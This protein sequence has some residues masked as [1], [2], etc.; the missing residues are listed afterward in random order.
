MFFLLAASFSLDAQIPAESLS[1]FY[2]FSGSTDDV[3]F[4]NGA[5]LIGD[6]NLTA[7]R[8]GF[9]NCA[10]SFGGHDT[11]LMLIQGCCGFQV[12]QDSSFTISLWY[13]HG[14]AD[15]G[16]FE[17]LFYKGW[18]PND[19][20][21]FGIS[22]YD[23]NTPLMYSIEE[24]LWCDQSLITFPDDSLWH[25]LAIVYEPDHWAMY[26]DNQLG[27]EL[28]GSQANIHFMAADVHLGTNFE[29]HLDDIAFYNKA[30]NQNEILQLYNAPS[31][32]T[33]GLG[34]LNYEIDVDI[35]PQPATEVLSIRLKEI[36]AKTFEILTVEGKLAHSENI[37][38]QNFQIQ[39]DH[40]SKGLY[41]IR[42]L[43]D[44]QVLG[45]KSFIVN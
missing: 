22:L 38:T 28:N 18:H 30:L 7:D 41:T 29:G 12:S 2:P 3:I 14:S 42:F 10:Y 6:V 15:A 8:F 35:Y 39:L 21:S 27:A 16:D 33:T 43:K 40:F 5:I 36:Q 24:F 31:S 11:S 45:Y 25:H 19:S 37:S 4:N 44:D 32:C 13:K 17:H 23:L 20:V 26:F 34:D 9:E 1:H